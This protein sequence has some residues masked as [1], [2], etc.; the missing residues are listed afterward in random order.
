MRR[1]YAYFLDEEIFDKNEDLHIVNCGYDTMVTKN[2][3]YKRVRND[4]Y[5]LLVTQGTCTHIYRKKKY[6]LSPGNM[7]LYY[8][9]EQQEYFCQ[10]KDQS[11][12]RW[13]HFSGTKAVQFMQS[14][15]ISGGP[16]Y[17]D[18]TDKIL[19]LHHLML[20]EYKHREMFFNEIAIN[21]LRE[22][23]YIIA[24][25]KNRFEIN[26][27]FNEIIEIIMNNPAI[28]NQECAKICRCSTV[29][30]VR[31][32]KQAYGTTPHKY[33]QR[34]L[35]N[36]MMDMLSSTNKPFATIAEILGF[37]KNPSYANKLF[38]QMTGLTPTE[39][40]QQKKDSD[41]ND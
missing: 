15:N 34:I 9:N 16:I 21:Y 2:I 14:L 26:T 7:F 20:N 18:S 28:S 32:F 35:L 30:F 23:L 11:S 4:F 40:R 24:R 33:K 3:H 27:K 19:K 17:L 8:P 13:I 29:H 39:Y 41:I 38:K 31:L 36:Q 10:C 6:V 37:E 25:S 12:W 5:L 1:F 22:I